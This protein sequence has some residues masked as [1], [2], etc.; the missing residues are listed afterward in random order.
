MSIWYV[1]EGR[2]SNA[3]SHPERVLRG[4]L[5]DEEQV[6]RLHAFTALPAQFAAI[7]YAAESLVVPKSVG[8]TAGDPQVAQIAHLVN[9]SASESPIA[10][11][12][13]GAGKGR[14]LAGLAELFV[15]ESD[16]FVERYDYFA[17]DS[18]NDDS[19]ICKA[20][21]RNVY[22]DDAK[23]RYF[24]SREEFFTT[25][26]KS[27]IDIVVMCNTL[28]EIDPSTWLSHFNKESLIFR[29]LKDTGHVLIVEDQRIPVGEK[30]HQYG[31]LVL[32]TPHLKTLFG[33]LAADQA[34]NLFV[35]HDYRGDGRLKAHL[36]SKILLERVTSETRKKAIQELCATA[37]TKIMELRKTESNYRNGQLH[38][39]WTQQFANASLYL[40]VV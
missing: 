21:I 20:A 10:F 22:G 19:E 26:D 37:K 13:F 15:T 27:S 28:H 39:F 29:A 7:N 3:G 34:N 5:G 18:S 30:A 25:Q 36:V 40:E 9:Q 31:F 4:L 24:S 17:F 23:Q 11:L 14:L 16:S 6:E 12:D 33:V 38:G 32:D 8:Q 1:E 35:L 2:V